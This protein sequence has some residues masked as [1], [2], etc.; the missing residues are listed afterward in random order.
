MSKTFYIKYT[1]VYSDTYSVDTDSYEEA[2]DIL[3]D[4]ILSGDREGPELCDDSYFE[5]VSHE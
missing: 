2:V 5:E 4:E 1:E 3:D